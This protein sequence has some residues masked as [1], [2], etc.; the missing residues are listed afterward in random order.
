MNEYKQT[1]GTNGIITGKLKDVTNKLG[2]Y[3]K[4]EGQIVGKLGSYENEA[5]VMLISNDG[6]MK[7]RGGCKSVV[8]W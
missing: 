1:V 7:E 5:D 6:I 2:S 4:E 8:S 3:L